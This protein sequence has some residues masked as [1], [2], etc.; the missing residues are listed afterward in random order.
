MFFW[1]SR[2][3]WLK[4]SWNIQYKQSGILMQWI[5]RD[6]ASL[7]F[8]HIF[9]KFFFNWRIIALQCYVG[10]CHRTA[11]ISHESWVAF[12]D[13]LKISQKSKWSNYGSGIENRP[14]GPLWMWFQTHSYITE[15]LNFLNCIKLKDTISHF[16]NQYLLTAASCNIFQSFKL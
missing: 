12:D 10:F 6:L 16:Q 5:S 9:F 11:W 3:D 4:R 2:K 13:I 8:V 7:N 14:Q 1:E 15:N